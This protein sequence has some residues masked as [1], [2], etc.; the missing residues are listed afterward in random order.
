VPAEQDAG[1]RVLTLA[2]ER[3]MGKTLRGLVALGAAVAIAAAGYISYRNKQMDRLY[4]EAAG[5]PQ[6]FRGSSQSTEAVRKLAAYRGRRATEML[7]DIALGHGPLVLGDTQSE[8]IKAL[9]KRDDPDVALALANLLQPHEGL[10]T[11]QAAATALQY[12]PCNTECVSSIL[13]YLERIWLGE[14]NY[15]DRTVRPPGFQDVTASLQKDQQALYVSLYGVL[16]REKVATYTNLVKV[17]GLGSDAPSAF[18][19]DLVSHLG[20]TEACPLLQQSDQAIKKLPAESYKAPRQELHG[21]IAALN[22][23]SA[24]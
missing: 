13:R 20:L 4:A 8:A 24:K 6:F 16:Q 12:L 19:L 22:C 11:R 17:Y 21:A 7:L 18:A 15:E 2:I 5:Y 23:R 9:G 10:A 14:P 3:Y 1:L